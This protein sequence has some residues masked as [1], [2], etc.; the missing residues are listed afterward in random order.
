ME[1]TQNSGGGSFR[2]EMQVGSFTLILVLL[3]LTFDCL[4]ILLCFRISQ[5]I[6]FIS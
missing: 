2:T 1:V 3:E 6:F 4:N 5:S